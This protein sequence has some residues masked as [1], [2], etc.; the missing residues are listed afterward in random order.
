MNRNALKPLSYRNWHTC[1]VTLFQRLSGSD[2]CTDSGPVPE[3]ITPQPTVTPPPSTPDTTPATT[4]ETTTI[5]DHNIWQHG[6]YHS[7]PSDVSTLEDIK[8]EQLIATMHNGHTETFKF[9]F[10]GYHHNIW[11]NHNIWTWRLSENC[12]L[13]LC[14]DTTRKWLILQWWNQSWPKRY[15]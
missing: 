4:P 12:S 14:R 7:Y 15:R 8:R 5:I 10:L 11:H 6:N 3:P 1:D 13:Y 9:W 2:G